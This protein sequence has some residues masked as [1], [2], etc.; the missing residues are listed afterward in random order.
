LDEKGK[1]TGKT[2]P[3]VLNLVKGLSQGLRGV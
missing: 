1:S 3:A 2:V